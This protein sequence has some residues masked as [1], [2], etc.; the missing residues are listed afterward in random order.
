MHTLYTIAPLCHCHVAC[1]VPVHCRGKAAM[2]N[3]TLI[4]LNNESTEKVMESSLIA[5]VG[6][7]KD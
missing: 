6:G 1:W 7:C 5:L 2:H 4:L 3:Q